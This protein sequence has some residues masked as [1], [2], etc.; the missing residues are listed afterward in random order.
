MQAQLDDDITT[1][2]PTIVLASASPRRQAL[3]RQIGIE[4]Q[5]RPM[6]IDESRLPGEQ[7]TRYV[8][9]ITRQKVLTAAARTA[10]NSS[11]YIIGADT[12]VV[13]QGQV[14][15]KPRNLDEAAG[16]W[17]RL[18]DR[19]HTVL[20]HV[21]LWHDNS[22]TEALSQSTVT[23]STIPEDRFA[24]YWASGEP[25]DKAG[26]YAIQGQAAV[27]VKRINGSYSGIMGLPLFETRN[28]LLNA[29]W[30]NML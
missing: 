4:A 17:R 13:C 16:F 27:W 24:R 15:G 11:H 5:V 19:E 22:I 26:G 7:P 8:A 3:L 21:A 23:F 25:V 10:A 14:L 9:R 20:T 18:S 30:Q 1:S 2:T 12:A 28:L 6:T 29:G